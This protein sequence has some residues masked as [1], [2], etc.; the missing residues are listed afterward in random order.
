MILFIALA[1][2]MGLILPFQTAIN[3]RL[4]GLVISPYL[5]SLISFMVGAIYLGFITIISGTKLTVPLRLFW[6]NPWWIWIG[7]ILGF[8][9]LTINIL[10][11]PHLGGVQTAVLPIVSQI[12]TGLIIDNFGWFDSNQQNLTLI[13]ILGMI[14]MLIGVYLAMIISGQILQHKYITRKRQTN[15][16]WPWRL[17]SLAAGSMMSLQTAINA[18]LGVVVNS[19]L[20]ASFISFFVG[21]IMLVLVVLFYDHG[22]SNI[23]L[24][25]TKKNPWW[26][27]IGGIL[28]G[29]Y[30]L[31]S[32]AMVPILGTGKVIVLSLLGQVS[33]GMLIDEFGLF[34]SR[35]NPIVLIQVIGIVVMIAGVLLINA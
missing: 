18:H 13:R 25:F 21:T 35:K 33:A 17:M 9:I 30:V 28:G 12:I 23:K 7:G 6:E 15:K 27:W 22:I 10:V 20:H 29:S 14:V 2:M 11:F 24:A 16:V 34:G 3:S 5:A 32:I 8:S 1:I 4:R 26:L 31:I 19:K